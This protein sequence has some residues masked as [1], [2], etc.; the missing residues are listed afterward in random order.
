MGIPFYRF[1]IKAVV[2][3]C[4]LVFLQACSGVNKTN[5]VVPQSVGKAPA[6]LIGPGDNLQI[7]VWRNAEVTT[8]VQVRPDGR[9]STPLVEAL[10]AAGKTP[11]QLARDIEEVLS[12]YI[13]DPIVTV[14]VRNFVGTYAQQI[15]VVGAA[16]K[17]QAILYRERM[18]LLDVMIEV[19]GIDE[20]A[21]GN[22]A[23]IVRQHE[24]EQL[25]ID[26]DVEDL[27]KGGDISKNVDMMPGD[28]LIIPESWF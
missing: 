5:T 22:K 16:A 15:R 28:I 14:I 17:P 13:K 2:I 20:F 21:N 26:V 25:E 6:Y 27:V 19:G 8:S 9:I 7:F 1:S 23:V 24:G 10:E 3:I 12:V 11:T 18:T 4:V